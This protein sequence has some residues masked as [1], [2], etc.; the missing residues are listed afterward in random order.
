M[1]VNAAINTAIADE[2][3]KARF[4]GLGITTAGGSPEAVPAQIRTE[5]A[6]LR[7]IASEARLAFD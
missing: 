3:F 6:A 2:D 7:K 1:K 4:A 5:T